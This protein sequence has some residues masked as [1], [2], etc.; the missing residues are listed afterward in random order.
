MEVKLGPLV[1]LIKK[2]AVAARYLSLF[3]MYETSP[4]QQ[5]PTKPF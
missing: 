2:N 3:P 5:T 1:R 4:H